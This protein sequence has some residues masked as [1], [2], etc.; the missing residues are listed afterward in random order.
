MKESTNIYKN[1][2]LVLK[3]DEYIPVSDTVR[4]ARSNGIKGRFEIKHKLIATSD[5]SINTFY[6]INER[7][8]TVCCLFPFE[9][10]N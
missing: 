7:D 3:M 4:V 5:R 2:I 6:I 8:K 9:I 10:L 1:G